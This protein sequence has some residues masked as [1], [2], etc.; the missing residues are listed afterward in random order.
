METGRLLT[1]IQMI[2]TVI[3][4]AV[5]AMPTNLFAASQ[6]PAAEGPDPSRALG[7]IAILDARLKGLRVT[8]ERYEQIASGYCLQHRHEYRV[9]L[10]DHLESMGGSSDSI[11]RDVD[12]LME[13]LDDHTR[14]AVS[15]YAL[16]YEQDSH[17]GD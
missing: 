1:G 12:M 13:L 5:I 3:L 11:T 17:E 8:P 6:Q 7:C 14:I 10:T 2:T 16:W 9:S 4:M 15:S